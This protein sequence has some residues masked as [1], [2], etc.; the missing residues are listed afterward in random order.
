MS[1][2]K[3]K[4]LMKRTNHSLFHYKLVIESA[5][6]ERP[7]NRNILVA[8]ACHIRVTTRN[9]MEAN[10]M[11]NSGYLQFAEALVFAQ[12]AKAAEEA[13]RQAILCEKSGDMETAETWRNVQFALKCVGYK[14]AA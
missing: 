5:F 2:K 7:H 12:G 4:S 9:L 6:P 8:F 10:M 3:S 1:W 13:A 14:K 11:T